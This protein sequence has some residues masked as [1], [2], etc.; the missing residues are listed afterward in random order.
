MEAECG[1]RECC[2]INVRAQ[3]N[4]IYDRVASIPPAFGACSIKKHLLSTAEPVLQ[5]AAANQSLALRAL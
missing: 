3:G 5:F 2:G 4:T 1:Q